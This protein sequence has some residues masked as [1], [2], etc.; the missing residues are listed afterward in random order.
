MKIGIMQPY[1]FPYIGYW[2]LMNVV[3]TYVIFDDVNYINRGWVNRNRILFNGQPRYFNLPMCGASQNK[4]INQI[5]VDK[6]E[7]LKKRNLNILKEAYHMAPFFNEVFPMI[8]EIMNSEAEDLASFIADSFR[9]LCF[10]LGIESRRILSSQIEKDLSL[11]GEEKIIHMCEKLGADHYINAIGGVELYHEEK[12]RTHSIK[13]SFLRTDDIIYKQ[14]DN[15]FIKN[16]SIIDI[17]MFN[18]RERVQQ[19]LNCCEIVP[20]EN[21]GGVLRQRKVNIVWKA[22]F[23]SVYQEVAA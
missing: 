7:N 11:R 6:E 20:A 3:D 4:M 13:L 21:A 8:K 19:M 17:M 12:F 1:F 22:V 5:A 16:L 10:Y 23:I 2:Q 9:F 14:F 15:E 18:P